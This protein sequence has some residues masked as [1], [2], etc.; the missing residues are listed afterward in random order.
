MLGVAELVSACCCNQQS[1]DR[2][3]LLS[4]DLVLFD[5]FDLV[6]LADDFAFRSAV[7]ATNQ[8]A[9]PAVISWRWHENADLV[10]VRTTWFG[11]QRRQQGGTEDSE[12]VY[13]RQRGRLHPR[14]P[15]GPG[16]RR[17]DAQPYLQ[18]RV[19]RM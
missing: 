18:R 12:G 2:T 9:H 17:G 7:D 6:G 19:T 4:G 16:G 3:I 15:G 1:R 5:V 13:D 8:F 14:P 11:E 10:G